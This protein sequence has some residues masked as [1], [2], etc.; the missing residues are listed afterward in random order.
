MLSLSLLLLLLLLLLLFLHN[1]FDAQQHENVLEKLLHPMKKA[2]F[3]EKHWARHPLV[4]ASPPGTRYF[5]IFPL[6]VIVFAV[7]LVDVHI[8]HLYSDKMFSPA[9]HGSKVFVEHCLT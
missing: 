4:I 8:P 6:I 1:V 9:E 5:L 7:Q 3:M 2:E